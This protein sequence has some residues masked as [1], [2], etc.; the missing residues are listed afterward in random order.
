M[1]IEYFVEND[2]NKAMETYEQRKKDS[3]EY[4]TKVI[5][6]NPENL[7]FKDHEKLAH[8]AADAVDIEYRYPR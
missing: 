3:L 1:E 4:R 7:R 2:E 6:I 8:Y 5:E